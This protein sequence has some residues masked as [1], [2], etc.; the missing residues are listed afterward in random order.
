MFQIS[1]YLYTS[2]HLKYVKQSYFCH[3]GY[4]ISY[5]FFC[6]SASIIFLIHGFIP[7]IFRHT[8]SNMI[9]ILHE[10]FEMKKQNIILSNI[11][12]NPDNTNNPDNKIK[13]N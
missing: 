1:K 6:L 8:G 10:H 3:L 9:S 7:D 13:K 5:S 12:P 4:A 2:S 11:I